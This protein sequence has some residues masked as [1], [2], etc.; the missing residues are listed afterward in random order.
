MIEAQI[1]INCSGLSSIPL[2]NVY[3]IMVSVCGRLGVECAGVCI[4]IRPSHG[5]AILRRASTRPENYMN[6]CVTYLV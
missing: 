4:G 2:L 5:F 1:S 3:G 6:R